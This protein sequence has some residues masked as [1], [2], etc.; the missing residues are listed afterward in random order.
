MVFILKLIK[1]KLIEYS[2]PPISVGIKTRGSKYESR[3][4]LEK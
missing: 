4:M 1:K 2:I 3:Y